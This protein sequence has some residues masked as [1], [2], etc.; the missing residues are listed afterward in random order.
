MHEQAIAIYCICEAVLDTFR[1]TDDP[2][3]KM[4]TSEIMTFALL[5]AIHYHCD[6]RKTHLVS[7]NLRYFQKILSLSRLNR[8]IHAIPEAV[9]MMVFS[10][11][12]VYLKKPPSK[13]FIVDSFPVKSYENHKSFRARIFQGKTYHGYSASK[14]TYFFGIK[15]HMITDENG[16]PCEFCFTSGSTT[17]EVQLILKA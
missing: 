8:R 14:K 3:C 15:V 17:D 9:W 5:S 11:L 16:I 12:Q 4:S 13:Y 2:Q 10:A 7:T 1:L 6:Y